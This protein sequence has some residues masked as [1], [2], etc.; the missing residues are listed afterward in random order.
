MDIKKEKKKGIAVIFSHKALPYW[1]GMFV[2]A[3][4]AYLLLRGNESVLRIDKK[5]IMTE[6]VRAGQF[7]DYIRLQGRVLPKVSIQLSPTEGGVVDKIFVEEGAVLHEGDCILQLKNENL[8]LQILNAE[9]DLAEKENLLRNTM[10][11]MEQQKLNVN[12]EKLQLNID[13]QRYK[14]AYQSKKSLYE[15][16]LIAREEYLKAKEDYELASGKYDLVKHRAVQDSMYR[17]VQIRQMEESLQNMRLNM[18]IIRKRKENLVVKAPIDGVLGLLDVVLGQSVLQGANIGQINNLTEYKVEALIDE[19]YIDRVIP[20]L[21]A[22]FKRS[23]ET[24]ATKVRRVY[25]E[26]R[27]GKFRVDFKFEGRHPANIRSGQTYDLNLQLGQPVNAIMI[28]RGT[29]YNKTAGKWIYVVSKDGTKAVR[30]QIE[31]GRQN[32]QYYEVTD[33]LEPGERVIV[34]GYDDFGENDCLIF[35]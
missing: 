11:L 33:G 17:S 22:T 31:L 27:E 28:P 8:D 23:D 3:F 26:V 14:R 19:H 10:I 4:V 30:R 32:P 13:V 18:Q 20:D 7:N 5:S 25:P 2:L 12:Q 35:K 9:A 34:S 1:M 15:E 24:F 21:E 29:F 16:K 6:E